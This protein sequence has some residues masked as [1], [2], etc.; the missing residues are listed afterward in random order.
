MG[1]AILFVSFLP[2]RPPKQTNMAI[3]T[4]GGKDRQIEVTHGVF[5]DYEV[6]TGRT[7]GSDLKYFAGADFSVQRVADF[8]YCALRAPI[9]DAGGTVDFRPR[10]VANWLLSDK[11]A[12]SA[13]TKMLNDALGGEE[14]AETDE[15]GKNK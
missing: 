3:L 5:Y 2:A 15:P 9:M 4:I 13:F 12:M 11:K 8:C 7:F 6:F 1:G 10:D 14:A